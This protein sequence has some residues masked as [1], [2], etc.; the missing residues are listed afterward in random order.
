MQNLIYNTLQD[1]GLEDKEIKIYLALLELGEATVLN[2]SRKSK[3]NRAS[4][5]YILEKM[6]KKGLV[7]HVEKSGK[8]AFAPTDPTLLLNQQKSKIQNLKS[9]VPDLKHIHTKSDKKP[10]VKFFEG[11]EGIKTVYQDTLTAKTEILDYANSKQIREHWPKY[12]QDYIKLRSKKKIPL[13]CIAPFDKY[14]QQVK[15]EDKK[16]F[17]QTRLI[18]PKDLNLNDEIK[19]YDNKIAMISFGK[20]PFAVIIES[21]TLAN[22][23]RAIFEMAWSFAIMN[24]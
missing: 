5:Y 11:I 1:L 24:K 6:K 15:S 22:T 19:I 4:I 21:E 23:Q 10:T 3:V 7:T 16:H 17:R 20:N 2:I 13:R 12:D 9:I 18:N 8:E 14:G